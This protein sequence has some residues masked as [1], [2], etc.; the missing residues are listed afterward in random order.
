VLV[1]LVLRLR[2]TSQVAGTPYT[3][4]ISWVG[5]FREGLCDMEA[6]AMFG[7]LLDGT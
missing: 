3:S 4:R 5:A 1:R 7:E 6:A 2:A